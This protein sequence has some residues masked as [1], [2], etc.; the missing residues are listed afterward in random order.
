MRVKGFGKW[1]TYLFLLNLL[2]GSYSNVKAQGGAKQVGVNEQAENPAPDKQ[3]VIGDKVPNFTMKDLVNYKNPTA[4]LSEFKGKLVILDF[5]IFTCAPCIAALPTM[6]SLQEQ[7]KDRIQ[8]IP[9]NP[10]NKAATIERLNRMFP[11]NKLKSLIFAVNDS[12]LLKNL[13][14]GTVP[15]E[16]WIDQNG[17]IIAITDGREVTAENIE[18]ALGGNVAGLNMKERFTVFDGKQP[19]FSIGREKYLNKLMYQ[20]SITN[21]VNEAHGTTM[22]IIK[23]PNSNIFKYFSGNA[24]I[25]T[26]YAWAFSKVM[27]MQVPSSKIVFEDVQDVSRYL[28]KNYSERN[29]ETDHDNTYLYELMFEVP[30][31]VSQSW[32]PNIMNRALKLMQRDL[33]NYFG[34]LYG[35]H[36]SLE[37][38]SV[39]CLII[40]SLGDESKFKAAGNKYEQYKVQGDGLSLDQRVLKNSTMTQFVNILT[41]DVKKS[42]FT[43][44][45]IDETN[46]K[47]TI[48]IKFNFKKME[49]AASIRS[50]LLKYGLDV[51]EEERLMDVLVIT[52]RSEKIDRTLTAN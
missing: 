22:Q 26:L 45:L 24:N 27:R 6:N 4:S 44:I 40:K 37:K 39:K 19:L 18:K 30:N 12:V 36:G 3:L 38:R 29:L 20:S 32:D 10:E 52:E 46:Y 8:I 2:L 47:G 13:R 51:V 50:Q 33:N 21:G 48:D 35:T 43:P 14:Y 16:V 1:V 5:W 31:A 49:N 23:K 25:K 34:D 11:G 9:A 41:A 15:H 7:F 17:T 42:D 28:N